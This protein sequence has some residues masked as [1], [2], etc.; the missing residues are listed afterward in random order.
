MTLINV[1]SL[2]TTVSHGGFGG[3]DGCFRF[4]DNLGYRLFI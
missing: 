3:G 4:N 1:L 2:F